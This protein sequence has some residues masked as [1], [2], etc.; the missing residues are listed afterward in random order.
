ME[1]IG[2]GLFSR[3][4][5]GSDKLVHGVLFGVEA[6]LLWRCFRSRFGRRAWVPAAS[7]TLTLAIATELA[8]T[9]IPR[10]GGDPWD[11]LANGIGMLLALLWLSRETKSR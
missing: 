10:R 4:P 6:W 11:L 8:Q 7:W 9:Q 1:S 5:P 3:L 2:G